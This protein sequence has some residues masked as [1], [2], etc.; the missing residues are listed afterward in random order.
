MIALVRSLLKLVLI[1][2]LYGCLLPV[3]EARRLYGAEIVSQFRA[4]YRKFSGFRGY[5]GRISP[6]ETR[7]R[8]RISNSKLLLAKRLLKKISWTPWIKYI[9]VSGS[10]GFMTANEGD[11]IDVF[12]VSAA[13]RL[14]LTRLLDS[15][16][17][18]LPGQKRRVGGKKVT[19]K[20]CINY[21]VS[22][23]R[24]EFR[25]RD[26][27]TALELV[28]LRGVFNEKFINRIY[29]EN[30]WIRRFF[31]GLRFNEVEQGGGSQGSVFLD[32]ADRI[33]MKLQLAYMK[34][35]RHHIK[36]HRL[37]RDFIKF[38]EGNSW[39]RRARMLKEKMS[40]ISRV[41]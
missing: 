35:R 14:W 3:S 13:G 31:P 18:G 32:L 15:V 21:Y 10:V 33:A 34:L 17:L 11:D 37:T 25:K 39:N 30:K 7:K 28:N 41:R 16:I 12:I 29:S 36:R 26:F 5:L 6:V 9:G 4:R 22:E 20:L 1:E 8:R 2:E 19:N 24:L 23:E 40:E 38:Y 27:F